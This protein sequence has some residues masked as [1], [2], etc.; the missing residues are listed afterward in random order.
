MAGNLTGIV[1]AIK[2][3]GSQQ[4]LAFLLT[5]EL[6]IDPPL[7]QSRVAEWVRLGYV[8][9]QRAH[10]VAKVTGIPLIDLLRKPKART[11]AN[12]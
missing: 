11:A 12:A 9:T 7:R 6:G 4:H 8:P 10:A 2:A 1:R 3:V 5:E